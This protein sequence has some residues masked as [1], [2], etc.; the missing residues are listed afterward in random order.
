MLGGLISCGCHRTFTTDP[1]LLTKSGHIHVLQIRGRS[2]S[3]RKIALGRV[4]L[5]FGVSEAEGKTTW[6]SE[7][8]CLDSCL[9]C[10]LIHCF[11]NL[12]PT[13]G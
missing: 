7:R 1:I 9:L 13:L 11:F 8:N 3:E 10:H 4:W 5:G 6:I 12:N 2:G